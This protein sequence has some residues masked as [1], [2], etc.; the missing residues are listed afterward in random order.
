MIR[1]VKF[2]GGAALLMS[3]AASASAGAIEELGVPGRTAELKITIPA[4][5]RTAAEPQSP[6]YLTNVAQGHIMSLLRDFYDDGVTVIDIAQDQA[7][8]MPANPVVP[9][10]YSSNGFTV[11]VSGYE[12]LMPGANWKTLKE[13]AAVQ[14]ELPAAVA[15]L[16]GNGKLGNNLLEIAKR[17]GSF[18]LK[19]KENPWSAAR[20]AGAFQ[21]TCDGARLR[22]TPGTAGRF[23][24]A[25]NDAGMTASLRAA[26]SR[27]YEGEQRLVNVKF[28][29]ASSFTV[30]DLQKSQDG[31]GYAAGQFAPRLDLLGGGRARLVLTYFRMNN[32]HSYDYNEVASFEFANCVK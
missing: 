8:K 32:S 9:E 17:D 13:Y 25:V 3:L 4:P 19:V 5:A 1:P 20:A 31:S 6:S 29:G 27:F 22:L 28:N 30:S 16:T 7:L 21:L 14:S 2:F 11:M 26:A 18:T 24:A 23:N 12:E 10:F 15:F